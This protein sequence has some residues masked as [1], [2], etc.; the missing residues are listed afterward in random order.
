MTAS[1]RLL[2]DAEARAL[3]ELARG[4]KP[5]EVAARLGVTRHTLHWTINQARRK[6]GATSTVHLLALAIAAGD[7]DPDCADGTAIPPRPRPPRNHRP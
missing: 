3:T 1:P 7:I 4:G 5:A 2:S 6:A